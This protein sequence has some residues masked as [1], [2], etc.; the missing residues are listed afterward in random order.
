MRKPSR[1]ISMSRTPQDFGVLAG[2]NPWIRR[3]GAEKHYPEPIRRKTA[4]DFFRGKILRVRVRFI[5]ERW[6]E[7]RN[8]E[9]FGVFPRVAIALLFD[10]GK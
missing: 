1:R 2:K 4:D 10:L 3:T 7:Y 6:S 9:N 5:R 8:H